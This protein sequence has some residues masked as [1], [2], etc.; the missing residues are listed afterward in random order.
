MGKVVIHQTI[1]NLFPPEE[2]NPAQVAPLTPVDFL[3]RVI[4]PEAA[5]RLIQEDLGQDHDT[6]LQTLHDS[7]QYGTTMFP[8]ESAGKSPFENARI[9]ANFGEG[10]RMVRERALARRRVLEEE[11]RQEDLARSESEHS[12]RTS[13]MVTDSS[14]DEIPAAVPARRPGPPLK[15]EASDTSQSMRSTQST[16]PQPAPKRRKTPQVNSVHESDSDSLVSRPYRHDRDATCIEIPGSGFQ[17]ASPMKTPQPSRRKAKNAMDVDTRQ[18]EE[19]PR[20]NK[21]KSLASL[22]PLERARLRGK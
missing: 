18:L 9:G 8:D 15:R 19:T 13:G 21:S 14:D 12:V 7:V 4:L 5:L 3:Q 6:A 22:P 16:R 1:F 20:A 10:E 17:V 2:I 11:E